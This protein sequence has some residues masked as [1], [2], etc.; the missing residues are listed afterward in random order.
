M[1]LKIKKTKKK[2]LLNIDAIGC[3]IVAPCNASH[4]PKMNTNKKF[5]EKKNLLV[6]KRKITF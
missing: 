6:Q 3:T 2:P 1:L 5:K 4:G